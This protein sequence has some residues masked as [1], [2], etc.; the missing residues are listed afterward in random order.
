M[1]VIVARR[2]FLVN[3]CV[4]ANEETFR[5]VLYLKIIKLRNISFDNMEKATMSRPKK[6]LVKC[7][8][9]EETMQRRMN[10]IFACEG[11]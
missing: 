11:D 1:V 7:Y 9:E 4:V 8:L 2:W 10:G 6:S 3:S 5:G